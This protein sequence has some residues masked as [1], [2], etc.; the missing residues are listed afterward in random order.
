[1]ARYFFD[2]VGQTRSEYDFRGTLF[3][4]PRQAHSWAEL[5]ALDLE[6]D[7]D[8]QGLVGGRVG[9]RSTD[10]RELFSIP[11]RQVEAACV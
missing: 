9:V 7:S 4:D 11:I 6:V 8:E 10:G 5:L 1:M 2:V 3:S